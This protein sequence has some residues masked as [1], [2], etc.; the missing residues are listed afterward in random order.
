MNMAFSAHLTRAFKTDSRRYRERLCYFRSCRPDDNRWGSA[1]MSIFNKPAV[2]TFMEQAP[3]R[4][5]APKQTLMLAGDPPQ[6]LYLILEGSVSILLR[7]EERLVWKQC[8]RPSR[9]RGA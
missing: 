8:V 9:S 7:S 1:S 4:S 3:K 2:R 6:S 5:Y